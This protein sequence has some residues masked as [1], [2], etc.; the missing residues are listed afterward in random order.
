MRTRGPEVVWDR[1]SSETWSM[2][3]KVPG[4]VAGRDKP[5]DPLPRIDVHLVIDVDAH[6][7]LVERPGRWAA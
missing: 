3:W 7:H 4:R 2:S 5:H 1:P 6:G